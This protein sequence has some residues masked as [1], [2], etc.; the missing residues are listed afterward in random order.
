MLYSN[1]SEL[2]KAV[3][4]V[5]PKTA[6]GLWKN[7]FN[8]ACEEYGESTSSAMAWGEVRKAGWSKGENGIW[9]NSSGVKKIYEFEVKK[10]DES[11]QFAFGWAMFSQ[12][13]NGNEVWDLQDDSIDP[14]ELENL[15]YDYV[16]W[17]RDAGEL[18][19]NSGRGTL[20]ESVVTTK[21][22]QRIWGVP[23]GVM[24]VGWWVGFY[25]SDLNVWQK[26]LDGTYRAFSIEGNAERV[27]V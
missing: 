23:D 20:I 18:H 25:V 22:K 15:A 1:N 3:T 7:A 16:L 9:I 11:Q 13:A 14:F 19:I 12:D 27:E 21:E 6:Q 8:S 17:Y 5:L 4:N 10:M 2:P 24:P 26:V